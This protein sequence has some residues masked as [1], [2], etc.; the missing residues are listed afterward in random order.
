M[1]TNFRQHVS[2]KEDNFGIDGKN[3]HSMILCSHQMRFFIR[4][5]VNLRRFEGF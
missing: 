5:D 1:G 4:I 2:H 3:T